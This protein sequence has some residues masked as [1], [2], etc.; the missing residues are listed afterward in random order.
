M[1][2]LDAH[3]F[4]NIVSCLDVNVLNSMKGVSARLDNNIR[5]VEESGWHWKMR[6]EDYLSSIVGDGV[7]L[8]NLTP[9]D[10]TNW[11]QLYTNVVNSKHLAD[12]QDQL[13]QEMIVVPL[14]FDKE[15]HVVDMA[16]DR[17]D[18]EAV[19]KAIKV[20]KSDSLFD[21]TIFTTFLKGDEEMMRTVFSIP[22]NTKYQAY[23]HIANAISNGGP[24]IFD[25]YEELDYMIYRC[26]YFGNTQVLS[27]TLRWVYFGHDFAELAGI[28]LLQGHEDTTRMVFEYAIANGRDFDVSNPTF[29]EA[30]IHSNSRELIELIVSSI[31]N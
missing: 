31:H 25:V 4:E 7:V 13:I 28:A 12:T 6:L 17:D 30:R 27:D 15:D 20:V 23:I 16:V 18:L 26:A 14:K 19:K 10:N 5:I 29:L 3:V 2:N 9:Q 1:E 24:V 22:A 11:S 8:R 21:D